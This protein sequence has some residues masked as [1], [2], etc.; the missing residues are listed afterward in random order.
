MASHIENVEIEMMELKRPHSSHYAAFQNGNLHTKNSNQMNAV[1]NRWQITRP[2]H[3][4]GCGCGLVKEGL[5]NLNIQHLW[6]VVNPSSSTMP[7]HL[8]A[9]HH[10]PGSKFDA[11]GGAIAK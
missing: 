8:Q 11:T 7:H 2:S 3:G 5:I 6:S 1:L 10:G 4:C 9:Q